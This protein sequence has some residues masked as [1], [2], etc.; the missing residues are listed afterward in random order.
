M[1]VDAQV[2]QGDHVI[3]GLT[4]KDFVVSD[5][6][7]QQQIV[8]FAHGSEAVSL[9]LLLDISGSMQRWIQRISGVA[10][11]AMNYLWPGDRVGILVFGKRMEVH[12][13]FSDNL[14]ESARQIGNAV[15]DHDVGAGTAINVSVA[16]AAEYMQKKARPEGRRAILILTDNLSISN[17]F[18]DE[19]VIRSLY[20]ADTVLNA[21]VVGRAIRPGPAKAGVYQNPDFTPADVFKLAEQTGG[22]AVKADQPE[23]SFREIIERIRTRYSLAYHVPE[24]AIAGSLRHIS[25]T[26]SDDARKR[27]PLAE[28]RARRGYYVGGAS[29]TP[30]ATP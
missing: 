29:T 15:E 1:H 7:Q 6:G 8:Y 19:N 10:R 26:L 4:Q 25:V 17:H 11:E 28:I 18:P 24:Y 27:Y 23:V 14:A 20:G 3:T 2:I 5:E 16:A 12:E 21:I 9:I 30:P 13:N 22:E